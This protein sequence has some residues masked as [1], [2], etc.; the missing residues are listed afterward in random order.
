MS[1]VLECELIMAPVKKTLKAKPVASVQ[2]VRR[3][4]LEDDFRVLPVMPSVIVLPCGCRPNQW[5]YL[6][7]L[8]IHL[9]FMAEYTCLPHNHTTIVPRR[10]K[11]YARSF[12]QF[13][14]SFQNSMY[15]AE[16]KAVHKDD[17]ST[18]ESESDEENDER[19]SEES[20]EEQNE[21]E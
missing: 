3:R 21:E 9:S 14:R 12:G 2:G 17:A 19:E 16:L 15:T 18:S 8:A 6:A 4:V 5:Q 20:E 13:L 10:H 7:E 11:R 1:R